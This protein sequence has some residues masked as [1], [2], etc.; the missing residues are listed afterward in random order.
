MENSPEER[1]MTS[2]TKKLS[3]G[4]Q[5]LLDQNDP[6]HDSI[7]ALVAGLSPVERVSKLGSLF[8]VSGSPQSAKVERDPNAPETE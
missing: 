1:Q 6:L 2:D 4:P 7:E 3:S 5:R 8:P